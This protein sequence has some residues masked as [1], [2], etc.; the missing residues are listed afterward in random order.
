MWTKAP[1]G[2]VISA[3]GAKLYV[4]G[5]VYVQEPQNTKLYVIDTT[6]G[7]IAK[8]LTVG[9]QPDHVFLSPD[10]REVWVAENRGNQITIVDAATDAVTG[11]I[12]A[13]GD[14]HS[15]RFVQF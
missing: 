11:T 9:V 2:A 8:T 1:Y 14:V 7:E 13:P 3:D 12:P 6:S 15:V 5:K 10:G 4:V